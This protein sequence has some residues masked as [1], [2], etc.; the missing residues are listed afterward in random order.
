MKT[1]KSAKS[2]TATAPVQAPAQVAAA[3]TVTPAPTATRPA[4]PPLDFEK[5]REYRQLPTDR[6]LELLRTETPK[7]FGLAEVVGKWVWVQ[8]ADKQ[9]REVTGAL[10]QLGFHWNNK[11][12]AWQHPCGQFTTGS[13]ADPRTKY[14]THFA[15]DEVT[16]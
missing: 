14:G 8:F 1:S 16:A 7:F 4:L 11:R 15:A 6:V 13:T 9:P 2:T 10:S 5:R 3:P 12:Q